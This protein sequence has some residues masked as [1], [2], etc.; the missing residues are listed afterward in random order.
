MASSITTLPRG[1]PGGGGGPPR[2]KRVSGHANLITSLHL[3]YIF[4]VPTLTINLTFFNS[5][6][7]T[8][9]QKIQRVFL[10]VFFFLRLKLSRVDVFANIE[11]DF[12]A[13]KSIHNY[14]INIKV[15][16]SVCPYGLSPCYVFMLK[17]VNRFVVEKTEDLRKGLG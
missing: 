3:C 6:F 5:F 14:I 1:G 4:N 12:G 17:P 8:N 7:K 13:G 10:F 16:M 11:S 15:F 2:G 9:Y